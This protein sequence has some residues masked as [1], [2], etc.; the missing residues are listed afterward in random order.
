M[1]LALAQVNPTV[2]AVRANAEMVAARYAE[3]VEAGAELVVFPELVLTGYPPQDLLLRPAFID[4]CERELDG[5]A[6]RCGPVPMLVGAPTR[7]P[8]RPGRA[9]F[10]SA[11]LL[12]AGAIAARYHKCLLPTY[13]VFDEDRYFEPGGEPG[14]FEAGDMKVG[15]TVCEDI[16]N[17]EDF[18]SE[19]RYRRDPVKEL[20]AAGCGLVVNLSAS[21]WHRGKEILR[22]RMFETT[23]RTEGVALA[24]CN[25]VGGNDQLVFDGHSLVMDASGRLLAHGRGFAEQLLLAETGGPATSDEAPVQPEES[26]FRALVL[27]TRDYVRKCGFSRVVIG[28]SGGIDSA[29]VAAIATEALGAGN[30]T[31]IS[32][33]ARISSAHSRDDA[34]LLARNLGIRFESVGIEPV[35]QAALGQLGPLFAGCKA[36]V[37]EENLQS[38]A[39]GMTLMAFSNKSGALVLTTGN[40]SELAV[41]YC[42]IYGDMCG[43]LAVISDVPK[44]DVYRLAQWV[45]RA[46][47]VIPQNTMTKA[48]SAE[49]R[50]DQTDQDTLPPYDV[51]DAILERYVERCEPVSG[52]I[53][54]GFDPEVV[55]FVVRLV[56]LS[57]Y[58]RQQAA[59]GLKVTTRAFGRGR[60]MPIAQRFIEEG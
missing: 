8:A 5:L 55:R 60:R 15:V 33:P 9:L 20:A 40:K 13:D 22:R 41:G 52:M 31:G 11:I 12:R 1:R 49:L 4:A 42:T 57:E 34:A 14:W 29:L 6:A 59:P 17:D 43:G 2:G 56:D 39:R 38:R 37:T 44:T 54:A 58:K 46:G 23:C 28:L 50:E 18:W 21:P 25:Q 7:N 27:G 19:R 3:A 32:M 36:D 30:V 10:N 35:F 45:N 51:L 24:Y 26:L 48:P 53:A 16:W 47:E